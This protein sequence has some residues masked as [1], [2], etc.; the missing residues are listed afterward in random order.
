[1]GKRGN[2]ESSTG[3][4]IGLG[5]TGGHDAD[6]PGADT[7]V[8]IP[9]ELSDRTLVVAS[10]RQPVRHEYEGGAVVAKP[11]VGGLTA[12]L[13][14]LVGGEAWTW[15]AWGDGEADRTVTDATNRV[16]LPP[17]GAAATLR[18]VWLTAGEVDGYY[19][20][21]SN[22]V[23]WPVCHADT[24]KVEVRPT[25]WATYRA[26]NDRFADAVTAECGDDALVWFH[27][28]HLAL[29]PRVV[30]Q[31]HPDAM[32][33]HFWHIPWPAWDVFRAC[34]HHEEVLGG[35]LANDLVGCQTAGHCRNLLD[36]VEGAGLG[37]VDRATGSVS[38]D[39]HRTYVRPFPI[40]ID[41]D[42][43][44][45][46]AATPEA[47]QFWRS[48]RREHGLDDVRL[49]VGIERLD[50]TKG[51]DRRLAALEH[52]WE[53]RPELRGALTYVQKGTPSRSYI[54]AYRRLQGQ[55]ERRIEALNDR[56][57]TD[58]WQPVVY[59]PNRL[60]RTA[61]AALYREADLALV[62]PLRDG[63]NLVAKEFV[64]AQVDEPGVLVLSELAGASDG[65]AGAVLV[66]PY[67]VHAM[68]EG[69]ADALAMAPDERWRRMERLD[70]EVR[71]N[72][73]YAWLTDQFE[74]VK[75][76]AIR[77]VDAPE[78]S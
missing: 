31:S 40:G 78:P 42:R 9:G 19:R 59:V 57:G 50:Y 33:M 21:Y 51:L 70:T 2:R 74:M 77:A 64:A 60:P 35:L 68:A 38:R 48:F 39:G 26:V 18:R 69:I 66:H 46:L 32:L 4:E 67:D 11:A 45:A 62:T 20:G 27:D 49:A 65:L 17:D 29:A 16:A 15:V 8:T 28:Y 10:N 54:P 63:M 5:G 41:A 3:G 1:M 30:R 7:G 24:A 72:D 44:T 55:V 22:R 56:F 71:R 47:D 37:S 14:P 61:L 53:T 13:A 12:A 6:R 52:L 76:T 58:D 34:P 73:V 36:C 25:D 43:W 75:Q 23:L